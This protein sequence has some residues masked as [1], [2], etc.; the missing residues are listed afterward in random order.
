MR[1]LMPLALTLLVACTG[2]T[3]PGG[4]ASPSEPR[5]GGTLQVVGFVGAD[6]PMNAR[7]WDPASY[8]MGTQVGFYRCCLLRRLYSYPGLPA[9]EGG[10]T[11]RPDIADG[12]PDVSPDGLT[13]TVRLKRGLRYAPPYAE[14]EIVADDVVRALD[15]LA[16]FGSYYA[17]YFS[18][19]VGF[20][21]RAS[22]ESGTIA[23]LLTPDR[24]TL[25][26]HL[27][28]PAVDLAE[29]L[30]ITP[31]A[32]IPEGA[33]DG[34]DDDYVRFLAA[35][36]PYMFEGAEALD[37][38]VPMTGQVPVSGWSPRAST[39]VRNPSWDPE[40]DDLR[41]AYV[42]RIE[43]RLVQGD[44]TSVRNREQRER[45]LVDAMERGEI[46]LLPVPTPRMISATQ[47]GDGIGRVVTE[48]MSALMY[49]PMNLAQ[50]PFDDVNVRRAVNLALDR[51]AVRD[52]WDRVNGSPKILTWHVVP[53]SLEGF[54]LAEGW[55]PSWAAGVGDRGD[56]ARARD[57]MAASR[58]DV[59]GD[60]RCDVA[61]CRVTKLVG[62]WEDTEG[63]RPIVTRAMRAI[64][65][66]VE[67]VR[68]GGG[69]YWATLVE[70][71]RADPFVWPIGWIA[72]YPSPSNFFVPLLSGSGIS[73]QENANFSLMGASGD[74]L[75]AW[76]SE[77]RRVPSVDDRIER[78]LRLLGE[79]QGRCWADLDVYVM[80]EVV[81]WAP[82]F[83]WYEARLLSQRI[84][85]YS[86][87]ASTDGP[88]FDRIAL[89]PE[90]P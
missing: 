89:A 7:E 12:M 67:L 17:T 14:R 66:D 73:E 18:P 75:G 30:A 49:L 50:P 76:G 38:A 53:G 31:T 47:Q 64:G 77:A 33:A 5:P 51:T 80:E 23:G 43:F 11:L 32:P 78:C 4:E 86:F 72:D 26:V 68:V 71:S 2:A 10:T 70:P 58:Y 6:E 65:I 41:E 22:G 85:A 29:R 84:V 55:R 54:R 88:S 37:P 56:I 63:A 57:A 13:W 90:S 16:T 21:A 34:H 82:V 52:G 19:I 1:T 3:S 44:F 28:T 9:D 24:H 36:G 20:D 39:F 83:E 62:P 87:D 59:D 61:A 46:D 81:P 27:R 8:S 40:T 35:S 74:Q 42:D 79:E 45:R 60:G 69:A 48:P 25:V 15:R